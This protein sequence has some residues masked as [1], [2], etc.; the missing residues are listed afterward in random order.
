MSTVLRYL[1]HI[2]FIRPLVLGLL[3][4]NLKHRERL[5]TAGPAILVANHNSHFDALVLM[6]LFPFRLLNKIRPVGARDY[7]FEKPWIA[8]CATCLFRIIPINRGYFRPSDGDPLRECSQALDM[9]EILIIFPEGTRGEPGQ[10]GPFK[11]GISHLARRH[12]DVPIVPLFINGLDKVLPKGAYYPIPTMC[13]VYV[14][15]II[16]WNGDRKKFMNRIRREI[17]T[18]GNQMPRFITNKHPRI[19]NHVH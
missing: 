16:R 18:L 1:I 15:N 17:V 12:P 8:W 3:G 4:L 9:N 6:T 13:D 5:P 7:F 2:V 11:T 10:I 19:L 14:G